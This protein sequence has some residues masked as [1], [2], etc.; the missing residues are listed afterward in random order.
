MSA[1]Q[2]PASAPRAWKGSQVRTRGGL[3]LKPRPVASS[4]PS[5]RGVSSSQQESRRSSTQPVAGSDAEKLV[6][7]DDISSEMLNLSSEIAQTDLLYPQLDRKRSSRAA[8]RLRNG[9][10]DVAVPR[11]SRNRSPPRSRFA[12]L[13]PPF[14]GRKAVYD[15]D[16]LGA[17]R[18][19]FQ[20]QKKSC[21]HLS[22]VFAAFRSFYAL[23]SPIAEI[24]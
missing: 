10:R 19:N 15:L 17:S 20:F 2:E 14:L 13:F 16:N 3:K 12:P 24:L 4:Q 18:T 6:C 23:E 9:P 8:G 5:T 22:H 21:I 1:V 11:T 7:A